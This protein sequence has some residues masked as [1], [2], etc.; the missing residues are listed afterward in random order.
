MMTTKTDFSPSVKDEVLSVPLKELKLSVPFKL[1]IF[2]PSGAGKTSWIL[3]LLQ[4]NLLQKHQTRLK[5]L[6][7]LKQC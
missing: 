1:L 3:Q 5:M 2:G 7:T 6:L 4:A